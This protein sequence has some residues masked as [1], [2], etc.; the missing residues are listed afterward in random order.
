MS[1][2]FYEEYNSLKVRS[3]SLR[4]LALDDIGGGG[5]RIILDTFLGLSD[6]DYIYSWLVATKLNKLGG[7]FPEC[8]SSVYCKFSSTRIHIFFDEICIKCSE[9]DLSLRLS[10]LSSQSDGRFAF[11]QLE[12]LCVYGLGATNGIR[13]PLDG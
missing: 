4:T 11:P 2:T 9:E 1:P 10:D 3:E 7:I 12:S 8:K 6:R 13:S 5:S